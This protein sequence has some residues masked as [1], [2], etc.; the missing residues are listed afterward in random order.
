MSQN[1]SDQ[2]YTQIINELTEIN[3]DLDEILP[4]FMDFFLIRVAQTL[5]EET[6]DKINQASDSSK[7]YQE[8]FFQEVSKSLPDPK[9]FIKECLYEFRKISTSRT[10]SR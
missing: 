6:L 7:N 4:I 1:Q 2:L 5:P 3:P 10:N 8:T 9:H